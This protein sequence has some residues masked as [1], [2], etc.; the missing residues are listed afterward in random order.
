MLFSSVRMLPM[1]HTL[2]R[3]WLVQWMLF[4]T[5]PA[6]HGFMISASSHQHRHPPPHHTTTTSTNI[7][8]QMQMKSTRTTRRKIFGTAAATI[9]AASSSFMINLMHSNCGNAAEAASADTSGSKSGSV[10]SVSTTAI[11]YKTIQLPIAEFKS[12]TNKGGIGIPVSVWYPLQQQQQEESEG[13]KGKEETAIPGYNY[14]ISLRRIGQLL[15]RWDFIPEFIAKEFILTPAVASSR[16]V[17]GTDIPILSNNEE[18][19][20]TS[21]KVVFLAHGFL[22]SRSDLSYLAEELASQGYICF[23]AE[24]PESLEASYPRMDGLTRSM[25]NDNLVP[26]VQKTVLRQTT[27][28][29]TTTNSKQQQQQPQISY[30]AIG[31]SLGCGTVLQL[32]DATW[33]RVL[34]GSGK[35]PTTSTVGGRV[36]FISS[37]NDGLVTSWGGGFEIPEDY[38]I[39]NNY[40]DGNEDLQWQQQLTAALASQHQRVAYIFRDTATAPNHI[41]YLSE[42][43]NDAMLNFLSPLLPVTKLLGIPV[44]D[45]DKYATSRDSIPTGAILKPLIT[46]FLNNGNTKQKE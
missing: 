23:A 20:D 2:I 26:Y 35:A 36:L 1:L 43:V 39:V 5:I 42:T 27:N 30:S 3:V 14:K 28:T 18:A 38:T 10:S 45:F 19:K 21:T 25:I 31:H 7:P 6:T 22:G 44:L 11:A 8:M 17:D 32:G 15:A 41:S 4:R 24:Y 34:M 33:N 13:R 9:V 12:D 40:K 16:I 29:N 46:T 37:V